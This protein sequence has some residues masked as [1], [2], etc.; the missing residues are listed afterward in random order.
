VLRA[1]AVPHDGTLLERE[2]ETR[3]ANATGLREHAAPYGIN[4][5]LACDRPARHA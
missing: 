4:Y 1:I 2:K 5:A 3:W